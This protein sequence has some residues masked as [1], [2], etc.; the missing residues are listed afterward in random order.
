MNIRIIDWKI[1]LP[2]F[3]LACEQGADAIEGD[4]QLTKEGEGGHLFLTY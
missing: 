2:A 1:I 3:K 4:F